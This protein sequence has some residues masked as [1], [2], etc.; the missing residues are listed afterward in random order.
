MPAAVNE[1][2]MVSG[3]AFLGHERRARLGVLREHVIGVVGCPGFSN[4]SPTVVESAKSVFANRLWLLATRLGNF[5]APGWVKVKEQLVE[6]F[7]FVHS[8]VAPANMTRKSTG[9]PTRHGNN[10]E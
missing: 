2:G 9:P 6:Y 3:G 7:D 5:R 10:M 8:L 1:L 4:Q